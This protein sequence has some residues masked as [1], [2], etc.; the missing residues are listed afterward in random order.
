MGSASFPAHTYSVVARDVESGQLGAA[1]QSHWFSVGSV[2]PWVEPGVGAIVTQS[3]VEASYGPLGLRLL[4]RGT[5][6][7]RALSGLLTRDKGRERRQVAIVSARGAVAAH[8]GTLC[9]PAAGHV[10]GAGWSVQANMM[11]NDRVVPEMAR[12][13][14]RS[15]G[16][17]SERLLSALEIAE[18]VGG[19][20]RGSQSA[21]I[22]IVSG[23]RARRSWE[24]RLMD[25][26]VDDHPNPIKELRRLVKR[27]RAYAHMGRGVRAMINGDLSTALRESRVALSLAKGNTEIAFWHAI[28]RLRNG[29]VRGLASLLERQARSDGR[30]RE[31]ARR[32]TAVGL[33]A[34]R[35]LRRISNPNTRTRRSAAKSTVVRH[36][37]D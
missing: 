9:V 13:M 11:A 23:Q 6:P 29:D 31:F 2:V 34:P 15:R 14:E 22:L 26:R 18:R 28:V 12:S 30:W 25:L 33:L 7:S 4:R 3:F 8:T 17:L 16:E 20:I 37:S 35:D 5:A 32:L 36:R 19:D 21:A 1:V 24:G 10:V 27:H